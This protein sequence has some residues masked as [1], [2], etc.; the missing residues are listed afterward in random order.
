MKKIVVVLVVVGAVYAGGALAV[1]A[2]QRRGDPGHCW[3]WTPGKILDGPGGASGNP[4]PMAQQPEA[5]RQAVDRCVEL[6][7]AHRSGLFG[8]RT[9][10]DR[11]AL[12]CERRWGSLVEHLEGGNTVAADAFLEMY[13]LSERL[14]PSRVADKERFMDACVPLRTRQL[15]QR[16]SGD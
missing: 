13:G 3:G 7:R 4:L 9:L 2:A 15:E 14:D 11:A 10:G 5:F 8:T 1:G 12:S 6:R 16:G